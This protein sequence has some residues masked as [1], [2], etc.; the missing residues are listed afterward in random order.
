MEKLSKLTKKYKNSPVQFKASL[1]YLVCSVI[2]KGI[3]VITT[4]IFTRLMSTYDYGKFNVFISWMNVLM[5]F[6]TLDIFWEV[7]EQ[8]LVKFSERIDRF[9][10]SMQG[11]VLTLV[12]IWGIVYSAFYK[13]WNNLF[14]LSTV[15]M[16][17]MFILIW[18]T[19]VFDFWAAEQRVKYKYKSLVALT[20]VLSV[21]SPIVGIILV[22]FCKDKVTARIFALAITQFF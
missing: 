20:L 15:Q 1:W 4:P 19:A 18:T 22:L 21:L 16:V 17:L 9:A 2:Q 14:L 6:F 3:S 13:F 5:V 8:G 10:S 11:L 12:C 7:F